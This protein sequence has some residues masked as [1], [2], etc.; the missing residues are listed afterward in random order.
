M[1][2]EIRKENSF[3]KNFE[4]EKKLNWKLLVGIGVALVIVAGIFFLFS[5]Q[6]ETIKI[7]VIIPLSGSA[8]SLGQLMQEGMVMAV[9]E[10]NSR[11]GINNRNLE[12]IIEDSKTTK[13]GGIEAFNKIENGYSPLIYLSGTSVVS[14][15]VAPLA[16]EN[17][18]VLIAAATDPSVIK[19]REWVFKNYPSPKEEITP[20]LSIINELN[21]KKVGILY[22][23]DDFGKSIFNPIKIKLEEKAVSVID[24]S[25][26]TEAT[27]FEEKIS[28]LQDTDVILI[29][30]FLSHF[31]PII[32]QIK[33]SNYKGEIISSSDAA[34]PIMFNEPISE[35]I[36]FLS[37]IVYNPELIYV[38]ELSKKY[39]SLYDNEFDHYVAVGYDPILI[40]DDFL[41]GED[42]TRE[43]VRKIFDSEF[44]YSGVFGTL[45]HNGDHDFGFALHPTKIING[46]LVYQ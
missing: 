32:E 37:P 17:E 10:I 26:E 33:E 36:Y 2:E 8:E 6:K 21:A 11:G 18:V 42:L 27:N 40:L 20:A 13:A 31:K 34:S 24:E 44:S 19:E 9:D 15:A 5:N 22:L 46:K 29:I 7:G 43:N 16:E 35:G 38:E 25:F 23:N 39:E 14:T 45:N 28:K 12:L 3:N 1:V 4:N 30:G 41:E